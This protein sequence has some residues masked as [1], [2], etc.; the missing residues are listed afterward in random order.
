[1]NKLR[2][3]AIGISMLIAMP[4]LAQTPDL[5]QSAPGPESARRSAAPKNPLRQAHKAERPRLEPLAAPTSE[6]REHSASRR[7]SSR[8][9][10][11]PA[12]TEASEATRLMRD[13]LQQRGVDVGTTAEPAP[14]R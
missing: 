6:P 3:I 13:E 14:A 7:Y 12:G 5:F 10:S 9:G 8:R 2:S 1:M 4:S 11:V